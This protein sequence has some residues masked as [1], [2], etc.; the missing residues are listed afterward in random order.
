M[1]GR[2][3]EYSDLE[4]A[5]YD[6]RLDLNHI[7]TRHPADTFIFRCRAN[8]ALELSDDD[9]LVVDRAEVPQAGSLVV[10]QKGRQ[11]FVGPFSRPSLV[12]GVVTFYIRKT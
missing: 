1:N 4:S 3:P 7:L 5:A 11:F 12:W 6:F 8:P 10:T 2:S 9:L